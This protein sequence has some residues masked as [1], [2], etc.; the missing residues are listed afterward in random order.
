MTVV[1]ALS[2]HGVRVSR[3]ISILI[4]QDVT[5][6]HH[7]IDQRKSLGPFVTSGWGG[8]LNK[9]GDGRSSWI[10]RQKSTSITKAA[11]SSRILDG[12]SLDSSI[13]RASLD[14]SAILMQ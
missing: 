2:L 1:L 5:H 11:M 10:A 13:V 4:L 12:A 6:I 8:Y 3:R 9:G 14:N 7:G